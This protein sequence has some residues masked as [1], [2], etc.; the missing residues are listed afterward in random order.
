MAKK[1]GP[2][3]IVSAGRE[4]HLR[5]PLAW[6]VDC[7][8][9]AGHRYW[10]IRCDSLHIRTAGG[11]H[12]CA[13]ALKEFAEK[14][15]WEWD[16]LHG[17]AGDRTL[18]G[19]ELVVRERL[20]NLV[21][22]VRTVP[23]REKKQQPLT[24]DDAIEYAAC[25]DRHIR[26]DLSALTERVEKLEEYVERLMK[27]YNTERA[28]KLDAFTQ[29][30]T[31]PAP[32]GKTPDPDF[33]DPLGTPDT[34]PYEFCWKVCKRPGWMSGY[35]TS[36]SGLACAME[37]PLNQMVGR[38]EG[39]GPISAFS[40]PETARSFVSLECSRQ[41]HST[42]LAIGAGSQDTKLWTRSGFHTRRF[43]EGTRLYDRIMLLKEVTR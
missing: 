39:C 43:P 21:E 11:Q 42:Y 36:A 22:E 38:L 14:F 10:F 34:A 24:P 29:A 26:I 5:E 19:R 17:R 37:Y 40:S 35:A 20:D 9:D 31:E 7:Y 28:E 15:A 30:Q 32:R 16:Y 12:T 23:R 25:G 4:F 1:V 13:E 8:E 33:Y 27:H 3:L 2:D 6:Q 41:T 18:T